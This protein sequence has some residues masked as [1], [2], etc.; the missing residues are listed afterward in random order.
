MKTLSRNAEGFA[1]STVYYYYFI[2]M[3]CSLL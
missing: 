3:N 2:F 1:F